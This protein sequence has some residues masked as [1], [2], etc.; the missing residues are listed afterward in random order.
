M[1]VKN[2]GA[3]AWTF[4]I[5]QID[6][7]GGVSQVVADHMRIWGWSGAGAPGVLYDGALDA[8]AKI[9]GWSGPAPL[10]LYVHADGSTT[11]TSA[12]AQIDASGAIG[13][14]AGAWVR[15]YG[16]TSNAPSSAYSGALAGAKIG[17]WDAGAPMPLLFAAQPQGSSIWDVAIAR[18]DA[19]GAV[20]LIV[21][22]QL[23]VWKF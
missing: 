10:I 11:W 17:G 4:T 16:W 12:I 8:N 3:T 22:D 15:A 9:P 21:A 20:G 7:Q 18:V 5:A 13:N 1:A 2:D 6:P 23:R 14:V 19:D